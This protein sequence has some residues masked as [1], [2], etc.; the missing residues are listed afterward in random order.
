MNLEM[1]YQV[2]EVV[3]LHAEGYL[4]PGVADVVGSDLV[5][6]LEVDLHP[7]LLVHLIV[8]LLVLILWINC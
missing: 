6:V 5:P 1:N 2:S 8:S 7:E 4:A 3:H